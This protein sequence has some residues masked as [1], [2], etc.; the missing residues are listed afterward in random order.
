MK[1]TT[2]QM[3]LIEMIARQSETKTVGF[4][5]ER[6]NV[7]RRTLYNDLKAIQPYL[8]AIGLQTHAKNGLGIEVEHT[9]QPVK[10]PEVSVVV[11][12]EQRQIEIMKRLLF[13]GETLT[14]QGLSE[15]YFVSVSSIRS[16]LSAIRKRFTND[17]TALIKSTVS[18]TKLVGSE[19]SIQMTMIQF[20]EQV[21]KKIDEPASIALYSASIVQCVQSILDD[22]E[23]SGIEFIADHYFVNVANALIVLAYRVNLGYHMT[24]N[25]KSNDLFLADQLS[26]LPTY[27]VAKDG[28]YRLSQDLNLEFRDDDVL[29]IAKQMIANRVEFKNMRTLEDDQYGSAVGRVI[30]KMSACLD[31]DL[32]KDD[33]LYSQLLRHFKPMIYRLKNNILIQN[34][35]ID[36]IKNEFRV[37]FDLITMVMESEAETLAVQFTEAEIGFIAIYFQTAVEKRVKMKRVLIVCPTGISTSQLVVNRLRNILP[38]LDI[39]EVASINNMLKSDLEKVDFVVSTVP[40]EV[41]NVPVLIVSPLLSEDDVRHIYKF[42]NREFVENKELKQVNSYPN[43][44]AYLQKD[45][46][47]FADEPLTQE[48]VLA[49][50]SAA[51]LKR[52]YVE[53]GYEAS[54]IHRE[55][56]GGTGMQSQAAIPHGDTKLVNKTAVSFFVLKHAVKWG[57]FSVKF[58][59][60]FNI[61]ADEV[62]KAR[63]ILSDIFSLIKSKDKVEELSSKKS[64]EEIIECIGG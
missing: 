57:D 58:V 38:P 16:D 41:E 48:E 15:E 26:E 61:K 17:G 40:I 5:A 25:K 36:Q 53:A 28:L 45:L 44:L 9:G 31:V 21:F 47:L 49:Q 22:F 63:P 42:Y 6:L 1:L 52:G 60:F 3:K 4:Y 14:Y 35:L 64:I 56:L 8:H 10:L 43:L 7:S 18:G 20:N 27:L 46:I 54:L 29:Y 37:I 19:L 39:I 55:S 62:R 32:S 59:V 33:L 13:G 24:L 50:M 2:R 23:A 34:T 30:E 12:V 51:L 11:D